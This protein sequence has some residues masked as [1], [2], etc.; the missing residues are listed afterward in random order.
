MHAVF[1]PLNAFITVIIV[2]T[3]LILLGVPPEV[4]FAAS[5]LIDL[6]TLISH[7]NVDI[8]AGLFNYIFIGTELHRHHHSA[9]RIGSKNYGSVL[10]VWDIIFGTFFYK[11]GI[12]PE[13]LGVYDPE[14][15]PAS[16][17]II[18]VIVYPFRRSERG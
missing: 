5:I 16:E 2:Q 15:Y 17:D 3:P 6:Q 10:S 9:D 13:K 4:A 12:I 11:P 1:N 7:F 14:L 8:R 18:K